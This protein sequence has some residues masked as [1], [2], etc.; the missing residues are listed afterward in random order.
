MKRIHAICAEYFLLFCGLFTISVAGADTLGSSGISI[1]HF[2]RLAPSLTIGGDRYADAG[3]EKLRARPHTADVVFEAFGRRFTLDLEANVR[4]T[5]GLEKTST[6]ASGF[7]RGRLRDS[8]DSWVRFSVIGSRLAGLLW[9]GR[10]LYAID[11]ADDILPAVPAGALEASADPVIYRL[12]DVR[13]EPGALSCAVDVPPIGETGMDRYRAMA[14]EIRENM[15]AAQTGAFSQ[16]DLGLIGDFEFVQRFGSNSEAELLARLNIV[17]GIY[18]EQVNVHLSASDIV[19]FDTA[20]DPFTTSVAGDL[21][22]QLG[23]YKSRTARVRDLGL[24]HL[25]TRRDLNDDIAGV[26]YLRTLCDSRFGAGVS[27]N[28]HGTTI[29]ALIA[30]HEIGH[31]FGAIHDGAPGEGCDSTPETFLMAPVINGSST[32]S[33]CSLNTIRP[34]VESVHCTTPL[35]DADVSITADEDPLSVAPLSEFRY[36]VTVRSLGFETVSGVT[37]SV[38]LPAAFRLF[39]ATAE[40]GSCAAA[41]SRLDCDWGAIPGNTSRRIFLDLEAAEEGSFLLDL[42]VSAD[43]NSDPGND[44][45]TATIVV[46]R[47]A[48]LEVS[49][50]PQ[51]PGPTVQGE[52]VTVVTRIVNRGESDATDL[53]YSVS[54]PVSAKVH[55]FASDRSI[56]ELGSDVIVC[57]LD[58]L[59]AADAES[60]AYTLSFDESGDFTSTAEVTAAEPDPDQTNNSVR[61]TLAIVETLVDLSLSMNSDKTSYLPGESAKLNA[62]VFNS[63]VSR[64]DA[65]GVELVVQVPPGFDLVSATPLRSSG[66]CSMAGLEVRCDLD[67]APHNGDVA[68]TMILHIGSAQAPGRY[69]FD[70]SVTSV[71][72][73]L[74]TADNAAQLTVG[75]RQVPPPA[76]TGGGGGGGGTGGLLFAALLAAL[77]RRSVRSFDNTSRR[78]IILDSV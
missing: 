31:N 10:E 43:R 58:V 41:G 51:Q 54:L 39:D 1:L 5:R 70:A 36:A 77:A 22:E 72:A 16:I 50:T 23:L 26:A 20:A 38:L 78:G 60:V 4:L 62:F 28:R 29:D 37:A 48:D 8:E 2:E 17:D 7:Y 67:R 75:V 11:S 74:N 66:R 47:R 52:P 65:T 30:A 55:G 18:S 15:A 32:F 9:D 33:Q 45:R 12:S 21:L 25:F 57:R 64:G 69:E 42:A 71:G 49:T 76:L 24:V 61:T 14:G 63:I 13:I 46:G 34:H 35:P 59:A 3:T 27:E 53:T 6:V 40:S 68:V 44:R 73:D 56:C 19:L